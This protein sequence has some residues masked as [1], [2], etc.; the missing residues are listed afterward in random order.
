MLIEMLVVMIGLSSFLSLCP[1]LIRSVD[2]A[3][4]TFPSGYLYTQS[5]AICSEERMEYVAENGESFTF[6]ENGNVASAMTVHFTSK[7]MIVELGGG[8]LVERR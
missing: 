2:T 3:C 8:R 1:P 6:N 4:F 7:D 5:L